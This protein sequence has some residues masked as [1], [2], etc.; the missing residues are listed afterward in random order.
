MYIL[1]LIKENR[2]LPLKLVKAALPISN[3]IKSN[4]DHEFDEI[5]LNRLL[6]YLLVNYVL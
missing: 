6:Y 3:E 1:I 4:D 2:A 5:I